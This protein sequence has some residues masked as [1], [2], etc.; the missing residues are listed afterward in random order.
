MSTISS[1]LVSGSGSS[2]L[3]APASSQSVSISAFSDLLPNILAAPGQHSFNVDESAFLDSLLNLDTRKLV[4]RN[5]NERY[6]PIKRFF[7]SE[8]LDQSIEDLRQ[9]M[10]IFCSWKEL[11]DKDASQKNLSKFGETSKRLVENW[12]TMIN[13]LTRISA[14]AAENKP[15]NTNYA[16]RLKLSLERLMKPERGLSPEYF[17]ASQATKWKH[18]PRSDFLKILN[19][20]APDGGAA[21][22]LAHELIEASTA[23]CL[24]QHNT[25]RSKNLA[26]KYL[27]RLQQAAEDL[28]YYSEQAGVYGV[29]LKARLLA[30][31]KM[32]TAV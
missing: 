18:F 5:L 2:L 9:A 22:E 4:L 27:A 16:M 13:H 30:D 12:K 29:A 17:E 26:P 23:S 19:G 7:Q 31:L 21:G 11:C 20:I 3:M 25:P 15:K 24:F 14:E 1:S 32:Q 28:Y 6:E 8:I 10:H